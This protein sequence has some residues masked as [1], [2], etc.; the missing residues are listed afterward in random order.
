MYMD[1]NPAAL[2]ATLVAKR[3]EARLWFAF[4]GKIATSKKQRGCWRLG[5]NGKLKPA[6]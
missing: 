3:I 6:R 1:P 2:A 5:Y 4:G